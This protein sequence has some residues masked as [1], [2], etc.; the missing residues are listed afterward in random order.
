MARKM[1]AAWREQTRLLRSYESSVNF[2]AGFTQV[3]L[4]SVK[5][6]GDCY[7]KFLTDYLIPFTPPGIQ[8]ISGATSRFDYILVELT[9]IATHP[10]FDASTD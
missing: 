1:C 3:Y 10:R 2:S 9:T 5:K 7:E 8:I 4:V 6:H